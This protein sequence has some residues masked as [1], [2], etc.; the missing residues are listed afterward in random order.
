MTNRD[1]YKISLYCLVVSLVAHMG[2]SFILPLDAHLVFGVLCLVFFSIILAVSYFAGK[3]L[4][5]SP[6]KTTFTAFAMGIIFVKLL[7]AIVMVA[8]Y[9]YLV[10]PKDLYFVGIFA[11]YYFIFTAGEVTI[12]M[13]LSKS[14]A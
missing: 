11:L 6:Q 7:A 4:A 10:Q 9:K 12:L 14:A 2:L 8:G 13:R 1:F 3:I 5:Q